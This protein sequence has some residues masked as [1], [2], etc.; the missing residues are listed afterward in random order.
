LLFTARQSSRDLV[1]SLEKA[2][3]Q[4]VDMLKV[5]GDLGSI[6]TSVRANEKVVENRHASEELTPL[7]HMTDAEVGH[8]MGFHL[9]DRS[10]FKANRPH[11]GM[12]ERG[13]CVESGR[14]SGS[15]RAY[16]RDD[17]AAINM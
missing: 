10:S 2:G 5:S 3:K 7:R 9:M 15:I 8:L 12:K 16:Q 4:T 13:N 1:N 11:C 14:F 6:V 17:L